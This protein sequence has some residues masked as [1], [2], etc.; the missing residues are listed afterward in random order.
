MIGREQ[1]EQLINNFWRILGSPTSRQGWCRRYVDYRTRQLYRQGMGVGKIGDVV[2]AEIDR[3]L[4]YLD[5]PVERE[6]DRAYLTSGYLE[7][8]LR[9]DRPASH[10][11][12]WID[13][14]A[15]QSRGLMEGLIQ[16]GYQAM[17]E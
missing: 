5:A 3:L 13:L 7:A 4:F 11:F 10:V 17:F 15:P 8:I 1:E 12:A 14:T 2:N 6:L 16:K 9:P